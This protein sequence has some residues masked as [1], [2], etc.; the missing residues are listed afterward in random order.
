M[1]PEMESGVQAQ[2]TLTGSVERITY[3][4]DQNGYTVLRFLIPGHAEPVTVTG[5]FS[6]VSPG[7]SLRLTGFW[8]THPQYGDQFKAADY[9]V[10]RP[11]T[12]AG[13]QKYLGS[14]LIKGVGPVTARRIVEHFGEQTLDIIESDISRLVEVRGVS[15][16]RIE[17]IQKTWQ[18]QRAVKDVMIFL[19]SH[20]VSTHFAVKIYKQYNN[21]SI[22]I[23]EKTPYRLAADIYGVGFRTAD[24]IARN[25]GIRA[26][27]EERLRAGLQHVLGEATEQGHCYLPRRELLRRA[28][29]TLGVEDQTRLAASLDALLNEGL[30]KIEE[31]PDDPL[32]DV[33]IY[34]PPLWQSERAIARRVK[35]LAEAPVRVDAKRVDTWLD[36]FIETKGIQLSDE[37]RAAIR[38]A[39]GS[40]VMVLTGG[41][42]CG[43]TTALR[44]LVALFHAMRKRVLLASP[45]G[46]AA[47]RLSEVTGEE[48]KTLHRTLEFDPSR[49]GFKRDE[50]SPLEA[51]VIIVDEASMLDVVLAN[52]L[53]KAVAAH[54][55]LILV[56]DVDQLPSVGPGTVLRDLIDSRAVPVARLTRVFRQAAESLIIQNAHRLN[57]GEFPALVKPGTGQTDCYFI[58]AEEPH[59]V[60]DLIVKSVAVALPKRFGYDPVNDIQVLAPMNRGQ[61]GTNSLNALL[62]QHLNPPGERK[63]EYA[64]GNRTLR[65]GDK[66]IQR[67]NNYKLEVFNGDLGR[68][69]WIDLEDQMIAVRFA[70]RI[71]NYDYADILELGHGF[72]ISCHKSQGSEYPAVVIPLHM[73]H[74]MMLSRNLLYTALTRAKKTVVMIGTTK[75]IGAAMNNLEAVHRFTGLVRELRA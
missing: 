12:V 43:K 4:N 52:Y 25:L 50:T 26:D 24:Q 61:V 36:R 34:L 57:R 16:K 54:S 28:A 49:M 17:L 73:Q 33:A 53:I 32:A 71:V 7:E 75:A 62:Q 45:T 18:E 41:P 37:Q 5:N 74:F 10:T 67:V 55:Q 40:R 58:A 65:V 66:V 1:P 60:A 38:L 14:G 8:T 6:A 27:A 39:A 30:L 51:D 35:M 31:E 56:G 22:P 21:D 13:I 2:Q 9:Q 72:A 23:V 47:Q 64:R 46:R 44:A 68:I 42:G 70:D 48:A 59:E 15:G 3:H 63:P 29:E 19:Q 20:G 69:E 11:A